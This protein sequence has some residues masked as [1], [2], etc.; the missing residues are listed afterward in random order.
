MAHE[1]YTNRA[2]KTSMAFVGETPWHGLGQQLTAGAS[3]EEWTREAGFDWEAKSSPVTFVRDDGVIANMGE[4]KVIYRGDTNAPLSVVGKSY[5]IVQP[6]EVID[7]FRGLAASDGFTLH[8]A[9]VMRGGR[10]MWALASNHTEA[11]VV[12]G[13]RVR[14]NL[15]LCTSLDGTLATTAGCTHVRVVCANTL[16]EALGAG[17]KDVNG[18][19]IKGRKSGARITH[20]SVFD[21]DAVK[22]EIGL[23]RSTFAR[24]IN[25]AQALAARP[26]GMEEAREILR[27]IFGQPIKSRKV[28]TTPAGIA[29]AALAKA[30]GS[31]AVPLID[32]RE[33][34]SVAR[35]L[36]LFA[37]EARG[38]DHAGVAGTR[39]GLLN[40]VT[41]HIDHEQGRTAD[42]R[43][44][45]AWFGRGADFK[46]AAFQALTA[47]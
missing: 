26:V 40:A 21:A 47:A 25:D 14:S 43:L 29:A 1:L 18:R 33:Q 3:I 39:W 42:N 12:P 30:A 44:S 24:F 34:K 31:A 36:A 8:T 41:E 22:E 32:V 20:R 28:D 37:G 10:S 2:G 27:G 46:A 35:C 6:R 15:L 23:C 45:S 5:Q 7:F 4:K 9:G 16:A 13:D 17:L 19:D 38:A 11:E